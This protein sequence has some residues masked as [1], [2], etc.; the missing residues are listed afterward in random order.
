M[1]KSLK[2]KYFL[3][4]IVLFLICIA[5]YFNSLSYDFVFDDNALITGNPLI[6][7]PAHL[8]KVFKTTLFEASYDNVRPN[9]Y[10]PLQVI[11]FMLDY[12]FW[13]LNPFGYHLTNIC[14]HFLIALLI[15]GLINLLF[16][17]FF[18]AAASSM[19]FCIHP[20]NTTAVTYISGR[21]D[22]LASLFILA[23][24]LCSV[25]LLKYKKGVKLNFTLV[26][27]FSILAF[28]SRENALLIPAGIF[29][30]SFFTGGLKRYKIYLLV[31]TSSL[32]LIYLYIRVGLL[33]IP[34]QAHTYIQINPYLRVINFLYIIFYYIFLLAMPVNLYLMH[35]ADPIIYMSDTRL[36]IVL[37]LFL[38]LLVFWYLKRKDKIVTFSLIWFFIFVFPVFGGMTNFG[39]KLMMSEHWVYLAQAGFYIILSKI[40]FFL[41]RYLKNLIYPFLAG[42]FLIY[43]ALTVANSTNLKDRAVLSKRILQFDTN[44]KEAHKELAWVYLKNRE[45]NKA[46][47]HIDKALKISSFDDELYL[48]RGIYYE[49]TANIGLAISSYEQILKIM[50]KPAR[51]SNNLGGIYFN[52]G[53]L[54]KAEMFF[55][56]AIEFN[57]LLYEPY[58]NLAKL[59]Y[60]KNEV[61]T[62]IFFY[63]KALSLNPNNSEI[64]LN[65]AAIYTAK[66]DFKRAVNALENALI[67][68]NRDVSVLVMLGA[69][70]GQLGLNNKALYYFKRALK[71][72]PKSDYVLFNIGVFYANNNQFDKAIAIWQE[73]L[74]YNPNNKAIKE[75]IDKAKELLFNL[76]QGN[77]EVY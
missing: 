15:F 62:A 16:E 31:T 74:K 49:D 59:Y 36:W 51:A 64:S 67:F 45:Y 34:W 12:C 76:K 13:K 71:L 38:A 41:K 22:L 46:I 30:L 21:A 25:L 14:L 23:V 37:G 53:D 70:N 11:S 33:N 5:T 9:Y 32:I 28:L 43:A 35:T 29:F 65:L 48:L 26:I 42:I 55:R 7:N 20:I 72:W 8:G 39:T 47:E 66:E 10:R 44:N 2:S 54:D 52:N 6:K 4:F 50:L 18:I 75:H 17:N 40:L 77:P 24:F 73:G 27:L 57:P 68:G 60:K 1:Q 58:L 63:K 19:L 69:L 61:I 56:R 3:F